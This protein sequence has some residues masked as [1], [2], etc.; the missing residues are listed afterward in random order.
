MSLP[1]WHGGS[2]AQPRPTCELADVM[3]RYGPAYRRAQR[4]PYSQHRVLNAIE[5]CRT[6]ALGGHREWCAQCGFERF[7][8]NSRRN[9]HCPKCQALVKAQWLEA[10]QAELLPVPY[11]H[12]VFTLPHQLNGLIF[13]SHSLPE[14]AVCGAQRTISSP[15]AGLRRW[16]RGCCLPD[17][18]V[19]ARRPA[20]PQYRPGRAALHPISAHDAR[21]VSPGRRD[22]SGAAYRLAIAP[23]DARRH[24]GLFRSGSES[25]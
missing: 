23:D 25:G 18:S 2:G 5:R 24:I 15:L 22:R 19:H 6:A 1:A 16:P 11:F 3:R 12:N 4:L 7:A 21:Q 8:Y 14:G 20:A 13:G 9:R 10:R 17:K